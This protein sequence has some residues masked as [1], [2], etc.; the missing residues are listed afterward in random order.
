MIVSTLLVTKIIKCHH[1]GSENIARH[2]VTRSGK[3][4]YCC[5]DCE[6][7]NRE[8]LWSFILKHVNKR[9]VR[10]ALCRATC[11]VVAFVIG[12]RSE[13]TCRKLLEAI[14]KVCQTVCEKD[15][16]FLTV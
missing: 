11:Q 5:N 14:P 6:R 3:Y 2:D 9:W 8:K 16:V 15:K 10:V 12:D 7:N 13:Q 1:C 4:R